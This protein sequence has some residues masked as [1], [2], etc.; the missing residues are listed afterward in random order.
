MPSEPSPPDLTIACYVRPALILDPIDAKIETLRSLE[1]EGRIDSLPLRS[2]PGEVA[3]IDDTPHLE[4]LEQY[5]RFERWADGAGVSISP[6]FQTRATTSVASERTVERLVTPSICLAC[7]DGDRLVGVFPHTADETTHA[8]P[9]AIASLRTGSLP[10]P[11]RDAPTLAT[12]RDTDA[13]ATP[14]A[15]GGVSPNAPAGSSIPTCPECGTTLVNVQGILDCSGCAGYH[16]ARTPVAHRQ[17]HGP[18]LSQPE[19]H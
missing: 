14:A 9:A 18:A 1:C 11:L 10:E 7:Y 2:W 13:T 19:R 5:D 6:P 15:D 4:V 16:D 17:V 8:V 12:S 3:Q